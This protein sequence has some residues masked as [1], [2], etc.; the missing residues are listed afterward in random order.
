MDQSVIA[1]ESGGFSE[2]HNRFESIPAGIAGPQVAHS[3]FVQIL[4]PFGHEHDFTALG[5]V[6]GQ[7]GKA[8][9]SGVRA[10]I[11]GA[12]LPS[13]VHPRPLCDGRYRNFRRFEAAILT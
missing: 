5:A 8:E 12:N 1:T 6:I 7:T 3:L 4:R 9:F 2:R 11:H 13:T 10:S